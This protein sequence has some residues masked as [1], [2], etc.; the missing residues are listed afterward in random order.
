[1]SNKLK[2]VSA[3]I[4]SS[5]FIL[6]LICLLVAYPSFYTSVVAPSDAKRGFFNGMFLIGGAIGCI[7]LLVFV[8][9]AKKL[10]SSANKN[11]PTILFGILIAVLSIITPYGISIILGE[12]VNWLTPTI[13]GNALTYAYVGYVMAMGFAGGSMVFV[14]RKLIETTKISLMPIAITGAIAFLSTGVVLTLPRTITYEKL[15]LIVGIITAIL[16]TIATV[17]EMIVKKKA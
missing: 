11:I 1:M 6:S 17:I 9:S 3:T 12:K 5:G 14:V 4:N 15:F 7:S 13:V 16:A 8:A 10:K 2:C